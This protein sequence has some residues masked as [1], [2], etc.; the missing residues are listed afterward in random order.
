[1]RVLTQ[2]TQVDFYVP[3]TKQAVE[4]IVSRGSGGE[5]DL[6]MTFTFEW[7]HPDVAEGSE[8][9]RQLEQKYWNMASAVVPHTIDVTRQMVRD[10]EIGR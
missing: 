5:D 1:M 6:Y 3:S 7:H 8:E 2:T 4:N 9:H 10:G